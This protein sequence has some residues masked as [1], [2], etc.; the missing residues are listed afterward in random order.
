MLCIEGDRSTIGS[1]YANLSPPL[2]CGKKNNIRYC[3][4]KKLFISLS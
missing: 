3:S 4:Q 1:F 2:N